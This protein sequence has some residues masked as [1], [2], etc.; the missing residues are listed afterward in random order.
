MYFY[1]VPAPELNKIENL[2][3]TALIYTSCTIYFL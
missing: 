1:T 3:F 2:H